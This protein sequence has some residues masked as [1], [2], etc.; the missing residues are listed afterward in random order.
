MTFHYSFTCN[1]VHAWV[2][3]KTDLGGLMASPRWR[4]YGLDRGLGSNEKVEMILSTR[5]GEGHM[6]LI[7]VFLPWLCL[8]RGGL[9]P[10][11]GHPSN[12]GRLLLL[13]NEAT[14]AS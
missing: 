14:A 5:L 10:F 6:G 13:L 9:E 12:P 1:P 8:T 2:V 7:Y 11:V 4:F 3:S